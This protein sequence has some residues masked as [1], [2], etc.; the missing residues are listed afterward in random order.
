[1]KISLRRLPLIPRLL[2]AFLMALAIL[3]VTAILLLHANPENGFYREFAHYFDLDNERNVPTVY[4]TI[5]LGMSAYCCA[6][7]SVRATRWLNRAIYYLIGLFFL[8]VAFDESLIL[9]ESSAEPIRK[10]LGIESGSALYH[11]WVLPALLV[12]V[13]V[14]LVYK[15]LQNRSDETRFQK[16]IIFLIFLL[17]AMIVSLEIAGT[18]VYFSPLAYKLGPVFI[19]EMIEI[20][21][22]SLILTKLSGQLLEPASKTSRRS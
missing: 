8:Y 6:M 16:R 5:I 18:Q 14:L 15:L 4:S 20:G 21:M 10:L 19:E 2:L 1:M 11:A 17:G 13:G 12:V 3:H 7:L 22:V 9:H